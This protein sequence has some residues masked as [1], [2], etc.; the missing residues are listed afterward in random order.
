MFSRMIRVLT[1]SAVVLSTAALAD[2]ADPQP[3]KPVGRDKGRIV[4]RGNDRDRGG[5]RDRTRGPEEDPGVRRGPQD[6][7][8]PRPIADGQWV[9]GLTGDDTD[10]G[11]RVTN[12]LRGTAADRAG[13][14]RDDIIVNVGGYQV[15]VVDGRRFDM[16]E[17]L[18]RQADRAG[19]VSL[20]IQNRRDRRLQNVVVQM[21]WVP[22]RAHVTG[23]VS[24]RERI[25]L[26]PEAVCFVELVEVDVRGRPVRVLE[27]QLIRMGTASSAIYDIEYDPRSIEPNRRYAVQARI[28]MNGRLL[29]DTPSTYYVLTQGGPDRVDILM[30]VRSEHRGRGEGHRGPDRGTVIRKR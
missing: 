27:K 17:E 14:E 16:G 12:V 13:L 4:E 24:Y 28:E 25:A 18:Q 6:L 10:V 11:V 23:T 19:R 5:D 9:L 2:D 26:P 30:N 1:L 20:L 22:N 8:R 3:M 21:E 7:R 15:G 29:M